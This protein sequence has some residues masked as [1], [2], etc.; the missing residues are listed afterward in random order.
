MMSYVSVS[1]F[2]ISLVLYYLVDP[3]NANDSNK[4]AILK[5]YQ[6]LCGPGALCNPEQY[7][8]PDLINILTDRCR[9]TEPGCVACSCDTFCHSLG[10]CCPDLQIEQNSNIPRNVSQDPPEFQCSHG[11]LAAHSEME[12]GLYAI[13][14]SCPAQITKNEISELCEGEVD[15]DNITTYG[16]VTSIRTRLS[17]KNIYCAI[18]NNDTNVVAWDLNMICKDGPHQPIDFSR[19]QSYKEAV[20]ISR[21]HSCLLAMQPSSVVSPR[22]CQLIPRYTTCA[23][24]ISDTEVDFDW[25]CQNINLNVLSRSA[26]GNRVIVYKNVFCYTC[27]KRRRLVRKQCLNDS[28]DPFHQQLFYGCQKAPTLYQAL[29]SVKN[30]Y[31]YMCQKGSECDTDRKVKNFPLVQYGY[32]FDISWLVE[33]VVTRNGVDWRTGHCASGLKFDPYQVYLFC[34]LRSG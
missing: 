25:A 11:L 29:Y 3:T 1:F 7:V 31:C 33:L 22:T 16:Y 15:Y 23:N 8:D 26:F 24:H 10:D 19:V 17:Y 12:E 20:D 18:C 2:M 30:A 27:N 21:N 13:I 28:V 4:S 32:L 34:N 9:V 6:D 14:N 5:Y